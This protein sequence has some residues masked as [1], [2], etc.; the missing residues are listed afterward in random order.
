MKSLSY[1]APRFLSEMQIT[2][3]TTKNYIT[4]ELRNVL[5]VGGEYIAS[6]IKNLLNNTYKKVGI[7]KKAKATDIDTY[8]ETDKRQ[9]RISG[10]L[11]HIVEI[12]ALKE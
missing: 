10:T 6:D 5:E 4:K 12:K 2:S 8:F 1:N 11:K 7:S 9:K 3:D